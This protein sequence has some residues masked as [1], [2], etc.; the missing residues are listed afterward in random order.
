MTSAT[1]GYLAP[2]GSPPLDGQDLLDF[3]QGVIV[4]VTGMDGTLV[5][6]AWQIESPTIPDAGN[7]FCAFRITRR[8]PDT[9]AVV[10]HNTDGDGSDAMQRQERLH[11]LLSFYDQ[12]SRGHADELA[13]R[14]RDGIAIAQNR[15]ALQRANFGHVKTGDATVVPSL[16]K[17]R[18]LYRVDLEWIVTRQIDRTYAVLTIVSAHTTL[19]TDDG[20]KREINI[21]TE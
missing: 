2:S 10:E 5:R 11:V 3:L 9:Y 6:P 8:S 16:L 1:G 7:A 19:V 15:E 18:W 12:G 21:T 4:G 20:L 17:V 13:A 14:F